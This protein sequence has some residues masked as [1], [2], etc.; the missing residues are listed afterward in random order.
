MDVHEIDLELIELMDRGP[1]SRLGTLWRAFE[2]AHSESL[3]HPVSDADRARVQTWLRGLRSVEPAPTYMARRGVLSPLASLS[4]TEKANVLA[5]LRCPACELLVRSDGS[6]PLNLITP[7][8]IDPWSSQSEKA[9]TE[10][11]DRVR[12]EMHQRGLYSPYASGAIC[13]TVIS[14]LPNGRRRVDVDNLVKGLL[15]GL[16][17]VLYS[18]DSQVQCLASRRVV[19]T[20]TV[21]YYLVAARAVHPYDADVVF[22]DGVAPNIVIGSRINR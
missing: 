21:G 6:F 15:D 2:H 9:K 8:N 22:D 18:N 7:I 4:M 12:H 16:Q 10:I 20:G 19:Y 1:E 3:E 17:G 11:R 13:L 14:V 5:Q